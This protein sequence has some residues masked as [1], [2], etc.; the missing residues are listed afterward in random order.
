MLPKYETV[1]AG[2]NKPVFPLLRTPFQELAT[3][4]IGLEKKSTD[5]LTPSVIES[6]INSLSCLRTHFLSNTVRTSPIRNCS[7]SLRGFETSSWLSWMAWT[8]S[9]LHYKGKAIDKL[10]AGP[11]HSATVSNLSNLHREGGS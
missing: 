10:I 2:L 11:I 7:W 3:S 1:W 4:G 8:C 9:G 5:K 6:K